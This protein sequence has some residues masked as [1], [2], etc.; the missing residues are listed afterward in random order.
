MSLWQTVIDFTSLTTVGDTSIVIIYSLIIL[1]FFIMGSRVR[2]TDKPTSNILYGI[3]IF[4]IISYIIGVLSIRSKSLTHGI[5]TDS[6][7]LK[8]INNIASTAQK[9]VA[10]LV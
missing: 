7:V 6:L 9:A 8:D 5:T 2:S 10:R 1:S 4:I 3:A